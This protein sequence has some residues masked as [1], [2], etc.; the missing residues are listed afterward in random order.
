M[1]HHPTRVMALFIC[2]RKLPLRGYRLGVLTNCNDAKFEATHRTFKRPFDLF[3]TAERIRASKPEPWHFRA[4]Q[5]MSQVRKEDWVHIASDWGED[6]LPAEA[7]QRI[8][9]FLTVGEMLKHILRQGS[10][11]FHYA[12]LTLTITK[13]TPAQCRYDAVCCA[14]L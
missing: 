2:P 13:G 6:I 10:I 9:T 1:G 5:L 11:T 7:M 3:V 8:R 12:S 4:F 14:E